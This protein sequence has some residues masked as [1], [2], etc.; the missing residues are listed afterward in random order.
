[1]ALALLAFFAEDAG[2]RPPDAL[3][4][5]DGWT[6]RW[7]RLRATWAAAPDLARTC[8]RLPRHLVVGAR[9]QG[10]GVVAGVQLADAALLAGVSIALERGSVAAI[11]R[12][13][14]AA[15]G[16]EEVCPACE[17]G[18]PAL[19]LMR[20]RGL[21]ELHGLACP[22]C[23]AV[24]R[25]YWRYGETDG[26]EALAPHALRLGVVAEATAQL[27]GTAIGFQML[28]VERE[29]LTA[30]RLR[31]RFAELYLSPYEVDLPPDAVALSRDG[32]PLAPG[33][34]VGAAGRLVFTVRPDAGITA[35][36]LLELLRARIERRFRP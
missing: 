21:D 34:R 28:P 26:L 32:E 13:V 25:S 5:A 27:A 3:A 11:A 17:G 19:H 36:E 35:E 33:A 8:A 4:T 18:A 14:L 10:D 12:E 9:L 29:R 30:D 24:L 31:R 20:T 15:L 22:S 23:G 1:V 6:S 2:A 16:P 7:E